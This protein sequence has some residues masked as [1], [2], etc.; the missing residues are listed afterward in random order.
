VSGS[1]PELGNWNTNELVPMSYKDANT[2]VLNKGLLQNNSIKDSKKFEYK[3][4]VR[5]GGNVRW[6]ADPNHD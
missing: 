5:E 4:L 1:I 2:W 6:E 3:F